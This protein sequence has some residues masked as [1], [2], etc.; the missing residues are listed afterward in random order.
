MATSRYRES[1]IPLG[2]GAALVKW[3]IV[4]E[5][6]SNLHSAGWHALKFRRQGS[7]REK[8]AIRGNKGT[9]DI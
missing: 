1:D 9:F 2:E 5:V 6:L 7:K 8:N 3:K 4:M